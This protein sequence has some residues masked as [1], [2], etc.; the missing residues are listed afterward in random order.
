MTADATG[1]L[2]MA[3]T[4]LITAALGGGRVMIRRWSF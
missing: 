1:Q 2:L 3:P 4:E